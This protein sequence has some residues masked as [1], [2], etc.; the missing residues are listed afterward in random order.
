MARTLS[1]L[2]GAGYSPTC[3][4][5]TFCGADVVIE[6]F[7]RSFGLIRD[8]DLNV[9]ASWSALGAAAD[10]AMSAV[11]EADAALAARA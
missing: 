4:S 8:Q 6:A 3:P 11:A 5:V 7:A 2:G 10:Q 9:R 1:G